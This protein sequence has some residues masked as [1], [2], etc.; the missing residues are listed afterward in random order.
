MTQDGSKIRNTADAHKWPQVLSEVAKAVE[1]QDTYLDDLLEELKQ[2]RNQI[3]WVLEAHAIQPRN[4]MFF[5][6][7]RWINS[8]C[9]GISNEALPF[10]YFCIGKME[11]SSFRIAT[12]YSRS[13]FWPLFWLILIFFVTLVYNTRP[14]GHQPIFAAL[15][16]RQDPT[17]CHAN[18]RGSFECCL[19]WR[20]HC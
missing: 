2:I 19:R 4:I 16:E 3:S 6:S 18:V 11:G 13:I 14:F 15:Q 5:S 8:R 10:W 1:N 20:S 17:V 12:E 9:R 7:R